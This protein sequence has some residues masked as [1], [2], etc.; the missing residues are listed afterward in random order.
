MNLY[1]EYSAIEMTEDDTVASYATKVSKLASDIEYQRE[2]L[3]D[4]IK[5]VRIISLTCFVQYQRRKR[6]QQSTRQT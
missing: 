1:E 5:M 4:N 6:P 3:P 2:K